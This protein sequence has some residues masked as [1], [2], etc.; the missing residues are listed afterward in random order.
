MP[1]VTVETSENTL[2]PQVLSLPESA[3]EV[4]EYV[5]DTLIQRSSELKAKSVELAEEVKAMTVTDE[6]SYKAVGEAIKSLHDHEKDVKE[7]LREIKS[8]AYNLH[9]GITA[10]EKDI[11][12][13][14]DQLRTEKKREMAR[15]QAEQERKRREEE[16]RLRRE[17]EKK[18]EEERLRKALELEKEGKKDEAEA[19][20]NE[21]AFV[22][23]PPPPTQA[24][25]KVQGV[26][27]RTVWKFKIVDEA[28]IPREYLMVDE[29][30]IRK[31]VEALKEQ[32]NIPGIEVYPEKV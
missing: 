9:K 4:Y 21:P 16:E 20:L 5:K 12:A 2:S 30:K 19:A 26:K 18:L 1:T 13:G 17:V 24:V 28:K 32:A 6:E 23:P 11:L 22:P 8:K 14:I 27:F 15:W 10:A 29:K 31:V 7:S 3:R 25:P